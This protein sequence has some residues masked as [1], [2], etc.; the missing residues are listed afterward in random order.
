ITGHN[1]AAPKSA[2]TTLVATCDAKPIIT[3]WRYGLGRVVS[4][5]TDD[6]S[7]WAGALLGEKNSEIITRLINWAIGDPSRTKDFRVVAS[8]GYVGEPIR[9][10]VK[11]KQQP[12]S[13]LV[14]FTE[15]DEGIYEGYFTPTE[16]GFYDFFG[17]LVAVNYPKELEKIGFNYDLVELVKATNGEMFEQ[18]DIKGI[19]NKTKSISKRMEMKEK[20]VREPFLII[21]LAL[22]L[23]E[24][25]VRRIYEMI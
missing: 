6:G 7:Y 20:T 10:L 15:I 24:I 9:I 4:I 1:Y 3:V 11:S 25:F 17:T 12:V 19:I 5:T 13:D 14:K 8:D 16:P 2:A 21:A 18:D 23:V 22:F